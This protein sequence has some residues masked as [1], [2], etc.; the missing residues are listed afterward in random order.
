[1]NGTVENV[2]CIQ[3]RNISIFSR[4]GTETPEPK[5]LLSDQVTMS[6]SKPMASHHRSWISRRRNNR[7]EGTVLKAVPPAPA[8]LMSPLEQKMAFSPNEEIL[9]A[10]S[11]QAPSNNLFND[12]SR[13]P[14]P[15]EPTRCWGKCTMSPRSKSKEQ[16]KDRIG[17]WVNGVAEWDEEARHTAQEDLPKEHLGVNE[18]TGFTFSRA[19]EP[20]A[21]ASQ[22][23]ILSVV[24]PG[25]ELHMNYGS[26]PTIEQPKPLRTTLS[27]APAGVVERC[28]HPTVQG[29]P[30]GA[31]IATPEAPCARRVA[32]ESSKP[33]RLNTS[34]ASSSSLS[35][36]EHDDASDSSKRSSVTSLEPS[37]VSSSTVAKRLEVPNRSASRAFSIESPTQAGIFDDSGGFAAAV[38]KRL[39]LDPIPPPCRSA[40]YPPMSRDSV[41]KEPNRSPPSAPTGVRKSSAPTVMTSP[42]AERSVERLYLLDQAFK[43][44][45]PYLSCAPSEPE[46]SSPTLSEAV[47]DLQA[48]LSESAVGDDKPPLPER[49]DRVG[50]YYND[51]RLERSGSVRSVMQPPARAPTVPKRSRKREWRQP[52]I[53]AHV[54]QLVSP[55]ERR[56]SNNEMRTHAPEQDSSSEPLA[57]S[58][59]KKCNS[60]SKL[61]QDHHSVP[62]LSSFADDC[63]ASIPSITIDDGLIVVQGPVTMRETMEPKNA[64]AQAAEGVLLSILSSL[65]SLD[66]LFATAQINKGMYR[67]YKQHEMQLIRDVT[68]NT[69]P[70]AWEFREW[71]PPERSDSDSSK[72][73][74]Q[75]EHTPLTYMHSH[76]RDFA[77]IQQLKQLILLRCQ[78]FIRPETAAALSTPSHPQAQRFTDAFWRIWC[79][80]RI[81]G[82]G[83]NR[84]DDLTGQLDWL[85]GG[86][87]AHQN[88]CKATV[89]A[90]SAFEY[91][92]VLLNAPEWFAKGNPEGGLSA[93]GLYDMV[94]VWTCLGSLASGYPDEAGVSPP[95]TTEKF[96]DPRI[97]E[98]YTSYL[99]THGPATIFQIASK[100][101]PTINPSTPKIPNTALP[102]FPRPPQ[103]ITRAHFL[104]EPCAR[105][106]EER[107]TAARR[108]SCSNV[109]GSGGREGKGEAEK[110]KPAASKRV[111]CL[112][113]EIRFARGGSEGC[114]RAMSFV[115]RGDEGNGLGGDAEACGGGA[116]AGATAADATAISTA[117]TNT[118]NTNTPTSTRKISPIIE[119]RVQSFNRLSG[120]QQFQSPR[121][122]QPA[123]SPAYEATA[124]PT[125]T[126]ADELQAIKRVVEMGFTVQQARD[127]VESTRNKVGG[128]R[129][130]RAVEVLLG[131]S[132]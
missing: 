89:G 35:T 82:S 34:R 41:R 105:L 107:V 7:P 24:I 6:P 113:V 99:L 111:E 28:G 50:A 66:D 128:V 45:S 112:A 31:R 14:P 53:P 75:L 4:R 121:E 54:P 97:L 130:V 58:P 129:V 131:V 18:K 25:S 23:P 63:L 70:A 12:P 88:G 69:S 16:L 74:S 48:R 80:C 57:V 3:R 38:R 87:L 36:H 118:N 10:I 15:L 90:N 116:A 11:E 93:E 123:F 72:A 126:P 86:Q 8:P 78:T 119:D 73:P 76:R 26:A 30:V 92:S 47:E 9:S 132:A 39:P 2:G 104:R 19:A 17:V 59:L 33:G 46:P 95:A 79:F 124:S 122:C 40:P 81:F 77:V 65:T 108:A 49:V 117:T 127:A 102:F 109:L 51:N 42:K 64:S 32:S 43:R 56:H 68:Y 61:P 98:E 114:G 100:S 94:E 37:R 62:V 101:Q 5:T 52:V 20:I 55:L 60:F 91:S 106:Y 125:T 103:G 83:R 115:A 22:R 71:C 110:E 13:K 84:E 27:F 1:M 67:V 120:G 21:R 85:K 44:A 96:H 29:I